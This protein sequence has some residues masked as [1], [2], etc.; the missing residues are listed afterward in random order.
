MA[1]ALG[2]GLKSWQVYEQGKSIP[3]GK[4]FEALVQLG[5]NANWL[6]NG[7]GPMRLNE[8]A[9]QLAESLKNADMSAEQL[10]NQAL[11][12]GRNAEQLNA[13]LVVQIIKNMTEGRSKTE[14]A[15]IDAALLQAAVET[16]KRQDKEKKED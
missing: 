12:I 5:F 1:T 16:M 14:I 11:T 7:E 4:V 9:Y 8:E 3:G 6:L 10:L 2:I 13:D 15:E